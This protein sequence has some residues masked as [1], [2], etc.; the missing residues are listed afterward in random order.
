MKI[1]DFEKLKEQIADAKEKKA[2]AEGGLK[3]IEEQLK[4]VFGVN[5]IKDA[6]TLLTKL[7][8]EIKAD[9]LKL[10]G[11]LDELD[12]ITDWKKI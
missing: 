10:K 8:A 1:E 2:M 11:M 12:K 3:Q 6:E 9:E 5:K 4:T 7:D